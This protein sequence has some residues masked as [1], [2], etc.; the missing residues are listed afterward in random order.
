MRHFPDNYYLARGNT[1]LDLTGPPLDLDIMHPGDKKEI[2]VR[3]E[4]ACWISY[5][6]PP[7]KCPQWESHTPFHRP[8]TKEETGE[9]YEDAECNPVDRTRKLRKELSSPRSLRVLTRLPCYGYTVLIA[10]P[11]TLLPIPGAIK[12]FDISFVVATFVCLY[13][14]AYGIGLLVSSYTVHLIN[15]VFSGLCKGFHSLVAAQYTMSPWPL[16][17]SSNSP[18][19]SLAT[20]AVSSDSSP[21]SFPV[22]HLI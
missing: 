13:V 3:A 9:T 16:S 7:L 21:D 18:L 12:A 6:I 1:D 14:V 10:A 4:S 11:S 5:V 8:D 22:Q 2:T 15:D 17:P 19:P 20:S